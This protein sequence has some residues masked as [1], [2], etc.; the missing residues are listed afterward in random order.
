M[1]L[2]SSL[3]AGT[4][5]APATFAQ[6]AAAEGDQ[7]QAVFDRYREDYSAPGIRSGSFMFNPSIEVG[8]KY[9]SNIYANES[10]VTD[11]FIAVIKPSFMMT[12]NW[13]SDYLQFFA[14]ADIGRYAD[15]K[16]ENYEDFNIGANGR[17]DIS[18]GTDIHANVKYSE[19]HE[20]RGAPDTDGRQVEPTWYSVFQA[21]VGFKRDVSVMSLAVDAT[22]EKR[23]FDNIPL[24]NS[25]NYLI[26][27]DR[28]R[29]RRKLQARVG[30]ELSDG[31]EAFV[32]GSIDRVEYDNSKLEGGPQRNSDGYEAVVGAA[33]DLTG[34]AKGEVYVGYLKRAYDSDTLK[35]TDGVNFGASLLWNVSGLTSFRG[36]VTRSVTETTL[37]GTNENGV[38]T[39]SSGILSTLVSGRVEHELRRNVLLFADASYTNQAFQLITRE[40]DLIGFK[41]GTKYLINRNMNVDVGYDY[42]YRDTTEKN[43]D[44]S[45][46]EVMVNLKAQW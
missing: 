9:A 17:K 42:K 16:N 46:H 34:K 41:L 12:S 28:D 22:Y 4:A 21:G 6:D 45:R 20:D 10:N 19:K 23:D 33:F 32:R 39:F 29:D 35:D 5:I 31:Y 1:I 30:Y 38:R 26:N 3:L 36:A 8:G 14:D 44:Y 11:D 40:D 43:Q 25:D 15:N 37:S 2:A 13:N 7:V 18:H 24:R 27:D